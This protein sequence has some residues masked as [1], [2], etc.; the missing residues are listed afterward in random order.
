MPIPTLTCKSIGLRKLKR[1]DVYSIQRY[2][3]RREIARYLPRMPHP[4]TIKDA[5]KWI[6]TT[7]RHARADKNYAFGIED[8]GS[9]EI[10][11][12]IELFNVNRTDKNAEVGYWV[13][14]P[15]QGRGYATEAI[16]LIL[17]FAFN[18]QRLMRIHA[19]VHQRNL[20]SVKSLEKTGFVRKGCWRKAS[21]LGRRW[22]DVYAY[23]ILKEEFHERKYSNDYFI[24]RLSF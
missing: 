12:M 23:G 24:S 15:F 4:Y 17:G 16:G 2:A 6:T 22:S 1:S 5:R 13:A 9:G 7:H 19:I 11:G 14:G 10:V 18:K 8:R 21:F 20:S 3:N